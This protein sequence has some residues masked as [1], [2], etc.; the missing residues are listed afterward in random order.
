MRRGERGRDTE[1]EI[2]GERGVEIQ[3]RRETEGDS[4]ESVNYK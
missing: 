1:K 4:S 3:R 2:R